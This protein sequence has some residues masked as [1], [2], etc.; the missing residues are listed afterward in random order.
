MLLLLSHDESGWGALIGK[1]Q[2]GVLAFFA[3]DVNGYFLDQMNWFAISSSKVLEVGRENVVGLTGRN[4]LRKLAVV[5]GINFPLRF[6]V[7]G[8]SDLDGDAVD[9]TI[10][11][12]PNGS[13][14]KRIGL[15]LGLLGRE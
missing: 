9:R 15:S 7:L 2:P 13:G 1:V 6:L 11:G 12:S 10:I 14:D 5:V 8:A 4:P 3:V